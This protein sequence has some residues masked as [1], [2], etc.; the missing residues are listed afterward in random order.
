MQQLH[1]LQPGL[2]FYSQ[3][4]LQTLVGFRHFR[5]DIIIRFMAMNPLVIWAMNF[6]VLA[7]WSWGS[8]PKTQSQYQT[9]LRLLTQCW[10][11]ALSRV[12][13]VPTTVLQSVESQ[14]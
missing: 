1:P 3:G 12:I 7:T 6:S 13:T 10:N 4:L 14:S 5:S 8:S 11:Q 2:A 9:A